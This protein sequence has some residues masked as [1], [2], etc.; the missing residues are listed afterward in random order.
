[1]NICNT[2]KIGLKKD[3]KI[4]PQIGP[5]R[6]KKLDFVMTVKKS[7]WV[8][9]KSSLDNLSLSSFHAFFSPLEIA[10]KESLKKSLASWK[11]RQKTQK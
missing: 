2:F 11:M 4:N 8:M 1:M 6:P 10:K 3:L 7:A 5:K 9:M